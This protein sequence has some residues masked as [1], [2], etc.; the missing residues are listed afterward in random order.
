MGGPRFRAHGLNEYIV[1]DAGAP[2]LIGGIVIS[3]C[4]CCHARASQVRLS[5]S[6]H[7]GPHEDGAWIECGDHDCCK[8]HSKSNYE[9][10][11]IEPTLAQ[12]VKINPREWREGMNHAALRCALLIIKETLVVT[13]VFGEHGVTATNLAGEIILESQSM[14]TLAAISSAVKAITKHDGPVK[15]ISADGTRDLIADEETMVNEDEIDSKRSA[16]L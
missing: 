15:L 6:L 1:L 11:E 8:N 14:M 16:L 13:L 7:G 5:V 9:M 2:R 4:G 10:L 3:G 12:F